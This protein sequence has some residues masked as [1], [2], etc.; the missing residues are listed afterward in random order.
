MATNSSLSNSTSNIATCSTPECASTAKAILDS[1][2]LNVDPCSDFYQ[3]TCGNWI[4]GTTIAEDK[5]S[6]GTLV[7]ANDINIEIMK[8]I[9]EGT[10]DDAYKSLISTDDGFYRQDQE[11]ADKENFDT[12]QKYYNVCL[13]ED[14]I[15]LVG[16]TPIYQDVASLENVLFPVENE[17]QAYSKKAIVSLSQSIAKLNQYF[18]PV[19]SMFYVNP[20]DKQ[21]D[22]YSILFGQVVLGLPSKEYY[23]VPETLAKYKTGLNDILTKSIGEY[24]NGTEDATLRDTESK[25]YNFTRWSNEKVAA[26]VDRFID[27]ET[28][29]ASIS[30][31]NEEMQDPVKLYN[32]V[33]LSEFQA[34]NP[35]IDWTSIIQALVPSGIKAPDTIVNQAPPYYERLNKLLA[36][37]DITEQTLQEYCI[38]T[39]VTNKAYSLDSASRKAYNKM[40]NEISRGTT[41]DRP[42]WE[43]CTKYV[44]SAF[45][46]SM[47]RYY[48]LKKFGSENE[49]KEVETFLTTIHEAWIN[50]L[51]DLD[52]LDNQ[53]RA[54]AV[55]KVKLI[56]HKV[57]YSIVSPDL[58]QPISI[59]KYNEGLF[60]NET[61]FY[62]TENILSAW[63]ANKMWSKAGQKVDKDEWHMSPQTVN[64][65]YSPNVN[66][67][68]LPAGILQSP[69]YSANQSNFLNYGG[70]GMIIGHEITHAFDSAG[71]K[72]DGYGSLTDWWT[73]TTSA[74]FEEKTKCFINQYNKFTVTGPNN[75]TL[76]VNGLLTLGENLADNG[77]TT[78]SLTAFRKLGKQE[79]ALPGLE[80]MSPEALFFINLGRVWCGKEREELALQ[81]I[82][83]DPHSPTR[84]RVNGIV[85][86][87]ADFATIFN[88][89][90][91]SPMNPQI[92]CDMW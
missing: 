90:V 74:K 17:M 80:N 42:R 2:D 83:T 31:K 49:R 45:S 59:K 92:K 71:R 32:P 4:A 48:T 76:N 86:N 20:D 7:T 40:D 1:L 69:L 27:F 25:K 81:S 14:Q 44:S 51:P 24:S 54:K 62:D 57:G 26:A 39:F 23:D 11:A 9:L 43:T 56:S 50:R 82:Y 22:T 19:L 72:Y 91:G 21:S 36:S 38:I 37:G 70:I 28:K 12:M 41:A 10:Y 60:I 5:I 79:Q 55:E 67:I 53:T 89:P 75:V 29:L 34:Q 87:S 66:E 16:P 65:Y 6:A 77:G 61:S 3:Y 63:Y 33:K 13:N 18:I 47:G 64:A 68:V 46:N 85:Q 78:A 35:L 58:R 84:A 88:C 52:W 73:N 30:M 15:D 8:S